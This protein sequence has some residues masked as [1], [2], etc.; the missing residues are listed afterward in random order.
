[1]ISPGC[2]ERASQRETS[3]TRIVDFQRHAR[4]PGA[5]AACNQ[6]ATV[7]EQRSRMASA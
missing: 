2:C 3:L 6:Y 1:M 5:G 7:G 4:R